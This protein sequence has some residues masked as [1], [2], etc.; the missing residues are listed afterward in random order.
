M[1]GVWVQRRRR[2]QLYAKPG[3]ALA[4]FFVEKYEREAAR[5]WD[6]FYKRNADK[7]FK[8]RCAATGGD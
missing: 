8:D 7:F 6:L 2:M 3:D 5:N 4:P 1:R